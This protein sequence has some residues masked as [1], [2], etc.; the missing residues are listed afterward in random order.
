MA[1]S[2][3][4]RAIEVEADEERA[5]ADRETAAEAAAI[6]ARARADARGIEDELTRAPEAGVRVEGERERAL[7]RLDAAGAVRAARETAFASLLDGI[8]VELGAL[9]GSD[10]Y[11][12]LFRALLDESRAALPTA[13]ELRVDRRDHDLAVSMADG[14]RVVA[15]LD[16]W[17]GVELAG[18]DGRVVRNTFEERLANADPLLR[19]RFAHRLV[20]AADAGPG[21]IR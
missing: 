10:S 1:L 18:D 13:R 16:T 6:V 15:T 7:A 3:L 14:L 5:L 11:A 20:T 9:R 2:D 21:D 17:G 8:R 12:E 4:L 19:G